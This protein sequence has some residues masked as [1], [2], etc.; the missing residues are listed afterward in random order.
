LPLRASHFARLI[1]ARDVPETG[2]LPVLLW[3]VLMR[4]M[5]YARQQPL[6]LPASHHP[7]S[8]STR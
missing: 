2:L 1:A 4:L 6:L 5:A 3:S 7:A 8:T